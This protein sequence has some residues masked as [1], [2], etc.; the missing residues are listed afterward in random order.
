M[1]APHL[2]SQA[3]IARKRGS[4]KRIA[5]HKKGRLPPESPFFIA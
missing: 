5:R 4:Y 3:P 1:Q 2:S